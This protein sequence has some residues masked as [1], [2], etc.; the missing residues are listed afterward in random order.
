MKIT[1][2]NSRDGVFMK[3]SQHLNPCSSIVPL[4]MAWFTTQC[5]FY[6]TMSKKPTSTQQSSTVFTQ[7]FLK[8]HLND[9]QFISPNEIFYALLKPTSHK[10]RNLQPNPLTQTNTAFPWTHITCLP[11]QHRSHIQANEYQQVRTVRN[12]PH[13]E[14][15]RKIRT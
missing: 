2:H 15:L 10:S 9:G 14:T 13:G 11:P 7:N 4:M 8:S 3:S 5:R 1:L 6:S 12:K